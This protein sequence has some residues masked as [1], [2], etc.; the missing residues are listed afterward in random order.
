MKDLF[1]YQAAKEVYQ[2]VKFSPLTIVL[3]GTGRVGT[4]ALL[5]LR[6]MGIRQIDPETYLKE[7][8]SFPVFT[9]LLPHHYAAHIDGDPFD[10]SVFYNDPAQFKSI[11]WPYAKHSD[12]MI[13]GIYYVE[14]APS[15]FTLK[16]MQDPDFKIQVISDISCDIAPHASIPST[17][18]TSTIE[19]PVYGYD[20]INN[21]G[22]AAFKPDYV[23]M[24]AV[25][26]LPNEIPREATKAFGKQFIT[27][28]MGELIKT[29]HSEMLER[30]TIAEAG[31]LKPGFEYLAEWL[32][33]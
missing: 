17:L 1:D 33:G 15:F 10:K 28:I 11:F 27:K 4:G 23:D 6:D 8:F 5:T 3:T 18:R 26:N 2:N 24:M 12:I 25:D 19:D 21:K 13:N 29:D 9:Q 32:A 16:Q 14:E 7:T 31:S 22:T 20:P 30:A